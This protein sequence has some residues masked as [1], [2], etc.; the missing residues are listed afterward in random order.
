M[1]NEAEE[2]F[3]ADIIDFGKEKQKRQS[4]NDVAQDSLKLKERLKVKWILTYNEPQSNQVKFIDYVPQKTWGFDQTKTARINAKEYLNKIEKDF[5]GKEGGLIIW[6]LDPDI[7]Y[8]S[9]FFQHGDILDVA[10]I[11]S[12]YNTGEYNPFAIKYINSHL[13]LVHY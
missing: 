10:E 7:E 8:P 2:I 3:E 9:R 11:D 12:T 6:R 4:A 1:L 5:K 13:K